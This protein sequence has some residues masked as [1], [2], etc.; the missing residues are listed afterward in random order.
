MKTFDLSA[1]KAGEPV[2]TR[3]GEPVRLIFFYFKGPYSI[4]GII[5][6]DNG[7]EF[8][9]SW[10]NDGCFLGD[11]GQHGYDLFMAPIKKQVW[12]NLYGGC[13]YFHTGMTYPSEEKAKEAAGDIDYIK[14]ILIHEYEY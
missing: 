1:A 12:I 5:E 3:E 8:A 13:L 2:I 9:F 11:K 4:V 14:T 6:D 7:A 10:Y